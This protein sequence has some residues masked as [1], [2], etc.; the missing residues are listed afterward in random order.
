[1]SS[2]PVDDESDLVE[3]APAPVLARLERADDRVLGRALMGG[4]VAVRRVVAA[5]DVPALQADAEVQ[6][7][8][9]DAQAV[10][11]AGDLRGQL[12]EL[13]LVEVRADGHACTMPSGCSV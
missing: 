11:A 1:M 4:R 12:A 3:V 2:D 7:L 9:P 5:T 8:A 13:D 10:L 6:P